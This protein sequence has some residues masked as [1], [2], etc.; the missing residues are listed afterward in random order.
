MTAA[1]LT[2]NA[3][4]AAFLA[5][6]ALVP[7]VNLVVG[8]FVGASVAGPFGVLVGTGSAVLITALEITLLRVSDWG[9]VSAASGL[10]PE[11]SG[12]ASKRDTVVPLAQWQGGNPKPRKRR[13][14]SGGATQRRR[15]A[16]A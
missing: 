10:A 3:I 5:G 15:R 1:E 6:L 4:A 7:I 13:A 16:A 11:A 9:Q 8:A 2:V 14:G 12:D